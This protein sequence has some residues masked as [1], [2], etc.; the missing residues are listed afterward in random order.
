[1]RMIFI[2]IF[3]TFFMAFKVKEVNRWSVGLYATL[4]F[5]NI[6]FAYLTF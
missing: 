1:M 4:C 2:W 5:G 3:I 6:A